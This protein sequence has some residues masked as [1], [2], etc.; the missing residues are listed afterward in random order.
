VAGAIRAEEP[1]P[2]PKKPEIE[3]LKDLTYA[4]VGDTDLQL[5]LAM[6]KDAKG[7]LPT[8]VLFH[9]GGWRAGNR[10]QLTAMMEGFARNAGYVSAT[11]SY[12]L[13]PTATFPA[14]IEDC[15]A[16]IRWL[17]ANADKY[18]IDSERIGVAGFSAGGHLVCLL[19]TTD[20]EAGFDAVE[21]NTEQSS[22]VQ[23]VV[24]FAGPTDFGTTDW[25]PLVEGL[26]ESL[27]GGKRADKA[28]AFKQAS[29]ITYVTKD[30]PPFLLIH[31]TKD[32]LV[33]VDQA[34]RF[35]AKLKE[36]GVSV[37]TLI[38]EGEG[39]GLGKEALNQAIVKM[40]EFLNRELKK[41]SK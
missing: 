5:D 7:K 16:A 19:G 26:I 29:P 31:G 23:A 34:A 40:T 24:S 39:H 41:P 12:R 3:V 22:R 30:D 17:R 37:E 6:P 36:T 38:L 14:Q 18:H 2:E 9:G 1:K 32:E 13:V 20:K 8:V 28:D 11:V 15:K 10:Q 4:R 35:E 21:G 27:L 25:S 33:P